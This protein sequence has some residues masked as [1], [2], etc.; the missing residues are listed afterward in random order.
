MGNLYDPLMFLVDKYNHIIDKDTLRI[1]FESDPSKNFQTLSNT[2][3]Y[4]DIEN[5]SL[6]LPKNTFEKLPN[7]FIAEI[8]NERQQ[9]LI[10]VDKTADDELKYSKDALQ[11]NTISKADFLKECSGVVFAIEQSTEK[12]SVVEKLSDYKEYFFATTSIIL[13]LVNMTLKGF[14]N[15][16]ITSPEVLEGNYKLEAFSIVFFFNFWHS[17]LFSPH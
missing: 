2:C 14:V 1:Q 7:Y 17:C 15:R 9:R 12:R 4:F 13:I 8:K 5:F 16:E 11:F 10:L 3:D 6:L